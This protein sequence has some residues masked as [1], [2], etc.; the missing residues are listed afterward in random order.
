MGY[1]EG[2]SFEDQESSRL[3]SQLNR[4]FAAM[5]P[6]VVKAW[7]KDR[8]HREFQR[9]MEEEDRRRAEAARDRAERERLLAEER[10]RRWLLSVEASRWAKSRGIR[11]YVAHIQ[12]TVH[13][14][15]VS[16]SIH[17]WT[18]WAL[19]VASE[20]DP[21]ESRLNTNSTE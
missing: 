14:R 4:I 6:L 12:T 9:Q 15:G 21:T 19:K 2:P 20:L 11:E 8:E 3:E 7:Q 10:T 13:K 16:E 1:R 17:D 5:Y 18:V